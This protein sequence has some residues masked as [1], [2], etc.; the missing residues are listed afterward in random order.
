MKMLTKDYFLI[1]LDL[2]RAIAPEAM[3]HI[4]HLKDMD[5]HH[6]KGMDI[7][8][9]KGTRILAILLLTVDTHKQDILLLTVH[10]HNLHILQLVDILP[11]TIPIHQLHIMGMDFL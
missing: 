8:H 3:G 5:I 4:L 1:L 10:T 11:P 7:H 9:H 2:L 6:H